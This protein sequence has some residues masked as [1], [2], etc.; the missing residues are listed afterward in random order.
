M[1]VQ[2]VEIF[3]SY[4]LLAAFQSSFAFNHRSIRSVHLG[5]KLKWIYIIRFKAGFGATSIVVDSITRLSDVS[6]DIPEL[7]NDCLLMYI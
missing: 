5:I 2:S 6:S 3:C 7:R 4:R 1:V